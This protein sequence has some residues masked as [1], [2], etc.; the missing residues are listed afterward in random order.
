MMSIDA[1]FKNK[2]ISK[3]ALLLLS[4]YHA[5]IKTIVKSRYGKKTLKKE[6]KFASKR[7]LKE[8]RHRVENKTRDNRVW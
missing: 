6:A 5:F 4:F 7:V 8:K 3:I 1:A 2:T